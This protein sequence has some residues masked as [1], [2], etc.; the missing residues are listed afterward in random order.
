MDDYQEETTQTKIQK[1]NSFI[2]TLKRHKIFVLLIVLLIAA[3]V[4]WFY[5]KHRTTG[6]LLDSL[7]GK[8]KEIDITTKR[9]IF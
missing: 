2:K 4:Y 1:S 5:Y 6:D 9:N 8:A 3:C 7:K